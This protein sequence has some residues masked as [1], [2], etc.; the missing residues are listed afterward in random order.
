M[1]STAEH[2]VPVKKLIHICRDHRLGWT[3]PEPAHLYFTDRRCPFPQSNGSLRTIWF[4]A[5]GY[6]RPDEMFVTDCCRC[7]QR[8]DQIMVSKTI[9]DPAD[10]A[11]IGNW[12]GPMTRLTCAPGTGC[13]ANP[14]RRIGRDLRG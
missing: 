7:R 8:A 1:T 9:H 5:R 14:R 12:I 13:D 2:A 11:D 3:D 10:D 4:K 6:V